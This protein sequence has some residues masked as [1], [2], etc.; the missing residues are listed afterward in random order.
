MLTARCHARCLRFP[1]QLYR[2][3]PGKPRPDSALDCFGET[4][5]RFPVR[6]TLYFTAFSVRKTYLA[7]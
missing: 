4:I 6:E 5:G 3:L 7:P 1:L 2:W